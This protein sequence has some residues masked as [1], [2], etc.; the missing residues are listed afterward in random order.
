MYVYITCNS[1]IIYMYIY[2]KPVQ[3]KARCGV[4]E[5][6]FELVTTL[7]LYIFT[8]EGKKRNAMSTYLYFFN[9][10]LAYM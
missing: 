3:R 2:L 4:D 1:E 10:A 6:L 5:Q 9:V 8:P 7:A